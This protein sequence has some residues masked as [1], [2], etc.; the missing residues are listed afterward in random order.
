MWLWDRPRQQGQSGPPALFVTLSPAIEAFLF[1]FLVFILA[2]Y[3]HLKTVYQSCSGLQSAWSA[4]RQVCVH[5][6]LDLPS[7]GH[8]SQWCRDF[9]DLPSHL[10]PPEFCTF[11][12][13]FMARAEASPQRTDTAEDPV[14]V[15]C[16]LTLPVLSFRPPEPNPPSSSLG[17]SS[18]SS[19]LTPSQGPWMEFTHT[20]RHM[21]EIP[22]ISDCI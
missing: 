16:R 19:L 4:G 21:H 18:R 10:F 17:Q 14:P 9:L 15:T 11:W 3:V 2:R 13:S 22:N 6:E 12:V 8:I 5:C 7:G 20:Y 1:Q